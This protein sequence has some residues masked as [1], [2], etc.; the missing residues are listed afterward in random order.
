M[1]R[2]PNGGIFQVIAQ[3][4]QSGFGPNLAVLLVI[5]FPVGMTEMGGFLPVRF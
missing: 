1:G 3:T 5:G 2:I 4:S